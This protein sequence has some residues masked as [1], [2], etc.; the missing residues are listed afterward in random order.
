[1]PAEQSTLQFTRGRNTTVSDPIY[2][3]LLVSF[4]RMQ[5]WYL[6]WE[7]ARETESLGWNPLLGKTKQVLMCSAV[8]Q[9]PNAWKSPGR[10]VSHLPELCCECRASGPGSERQHPCALRLLRAW[11]TKCGAVSG[12]R[13]AKKL[14]SL[15]AGGGQN[16]FHQ[17][18]GISACWEQ[19]E[20]Q[21]LPV[22]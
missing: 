3:H 1:M 2:L 22:E 21:V 16:V 18:S 12:V 11:S 5:Y 15:H 7:E 14:G 4:R 6:V 17:G 19:S 20:L 10:R 9:H 8:T 13:N